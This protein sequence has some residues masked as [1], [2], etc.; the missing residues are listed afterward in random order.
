MLTLSIVAAT[1][2][3]EGYTC[4]TYNSLGPRQVYRPRRKEPSDDE[5]EWSFNMDNYFRG[6][7]EETEKKLESQFKEEEAEG[8][9][10]PF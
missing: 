5:S 1:R 10:E 7:E 8:R 9:M 3:L 6:S 2:V 4:S